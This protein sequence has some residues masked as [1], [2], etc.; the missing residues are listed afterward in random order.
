[1]HISYSGQEGTNSLTGEIYYLKEEDNGT[2]TRTNITNNAV[3]DNYSTLSIDGNNKVHIGYTGRDASSLFQIKYTNNISGVFIPPIEITAA[4]IN[5]ATP[6]SK[7]GPDSVMHFV[8]LTYTDGTDYAFYRNYDLRTAT[9]SPEL[10]LANAEASGDFEAT[11]D[12]DS[13]GKVHIVVK[14]GEIFSGPLK[15]FSN[16]SGTMQEYPTG[17]THNVSY[18]R[19]TIDNNDNVHIIYRESAGDR[20][21]YLNNIGG[22]FSAPVPVSPDGQLPSGFQNFAIDDN[23]NIY[24]VYQSSVSA[25]GKGFYLIFGDNGIFSDTMLVYNLTPEYVTRNSSM[26]I[27]K[28]NGDFAVFYAPGAVRNSLVI[29]DIFRKKGNIFDIVPV[30]LENFTASFSGKKVTLSWSTA[31]ELN[32]YGFEIYSSPD[33]KNFSLKGFIPGKGS[34]SAKH[35]YSFID[36]NVYYP[37]T[38]YRLIQ[39][40]YD[41]TKNTAGETFVS[42]GTG[43]LNFELSQNYPNPFNPE[44][45]IKYR[46]SQKSFVVLKVFDLLGNT[47]LISCLLYT[48]RCV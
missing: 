14:S 21:H 40:D 19:I 48:S 37:E 43:E 31:T 25:S 2:F 15:Y 41:G 35:F 3:N 32:N 24:I 8:Y 42:T 34:S 11:L 28:G 33:N 36:E 12:I 10:Y 26:V 7:I 13:Q 44:T 46:I 45:K 20:L 29:C 22:S 23:G 30:E 9:L 4:G 6:F 27:A 17:V 1:M 38:Y 18:P 5:K 39:K 16:K 47:V